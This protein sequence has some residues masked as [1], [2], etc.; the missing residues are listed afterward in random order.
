MPIVR[1]SEAVHHFRN[2]IDATYFQFPD[3]MGGTTVAEATFTGPHG[4]RTIGEHPRI[5]IVTE[6]QCEFVINSEKVTANKGDVVAVPPKATYNLFPKN[7]PVKI[8]LFME[9]LDTTK[10]P[11]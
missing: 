6:G 10:L 2:G 4:E 11:K 3:I 1:E 5:Y 8:I 7:G 9:L